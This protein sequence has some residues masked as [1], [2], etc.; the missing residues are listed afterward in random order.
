MPEN[1]SVRTAGP[2]DAETIYDF[3]VQLA[4]YE[5]EPHAVETS[6][7]ELRAQL[8]SAEPPF[9]CILAEMGGASVGFAL[10]FPSYST[11]RGKPGIYLEDLFVPEA[12]RGRGI[13][14]TLLAHL[15]RLTLARGGARLEW[16]VLDWNQPSIEFYEKLGAE[17]RR[18]WLPCRLSGRQLEL[19]ADCGNRGS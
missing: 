8:A 11:W 4:V 3:I 9:E 5:R 1:I 16:S 7:A 14:T 17:I 15:A 10:F 6:A 2:D 19:L 13:G 18:E 12:L